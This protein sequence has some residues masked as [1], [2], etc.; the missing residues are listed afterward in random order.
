MARFSRAVGLATAAALLLGSAGLAKAALITQTYNITA[1]GFGAGAPVDP[2][3]GSFTVTF[4][5]AS[6]ILADTT[7]GI[8]VNSLNIA[9]GSAV[10]FNYSTA[11]DILDI[12][13]IQNGVDV[14]L[15]RSANT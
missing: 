5:N 8:T 3:T 6:D 12:G 10:G 4:D 15:T 1:S 2:V 9:V 13:G 7:S 14:L 11:G